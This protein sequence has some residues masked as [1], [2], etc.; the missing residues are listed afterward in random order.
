MPTNRNEEAACAVTAPEEVS[1][2]Q[3]QPCVVSVEDYVFILLLTSPPELREPGVLRGEGGRRIALSEIEDE[4]EERW[5][6][7]GCEGF[8]AR[9]G[10]CRR[11]CVRGERDRSAFSNQTV[12]QSVSGSLETPNAN[13]PLNEC[14]CAILSEHEIAPQRIDDHEYD[15]VERRMRS[16]TSPSLSIV[17][18][19]PT[20][21]TRQY[22]LVG[23]EA[24]CEDQDRNGEKEVCK[25]ETG[26]A[27][28]ARRNHFR[29]NAMTK[30]LMLNQYILQHTGSGR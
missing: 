1:R 9:H 7:S 26:G 2:E 14:H 16:R 20:R 19:F 11:S 25:C 10:N 5:D 3:L 29:E 30:A 4:I 21:K 8:H 6:G 17:N 12:C 15:F 28:T 23:E 22:R 24:S 27:Q 13:E 18:I